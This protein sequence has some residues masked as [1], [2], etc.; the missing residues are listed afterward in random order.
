MSITLRPRLIDVLNTSKAD[1]PK[2][3]AVAWRLN[4]AAK[5]DAEAIV[6]IEVGKEVPVVSARPAL[7]AP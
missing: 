4:I 2:I 7:T 1:G 3:F 5:M 6:I